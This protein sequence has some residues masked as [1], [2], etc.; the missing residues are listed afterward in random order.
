MPKPHTINASAYINKYVYSIFAPACYCRS[1]ST[2]SPPVNNIKNKQFCVLGGLIVN[3]F[4]LEFET[5]A[6]ESK[7]TIEHTK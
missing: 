1:E 2:K 5:E 4:D 7:Q 3:V 6:N